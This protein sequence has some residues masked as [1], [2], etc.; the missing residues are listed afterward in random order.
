MMTLMFLGLGVLLV[1]REYQH[2]QLHL[3][4][5]ELKDEVQKQQQKHLDISQE[6]EKLNGQIMDEKAMD[7]LTGLPGIVMF[8]DRA[9]QILNFSKRYHCQFAIMILD[10][11][12]FSVINN[13]LGYEVGDKLLAA[14]AKRLK[15]EIRQIDTLATLGS[16]KFIF[17]LPQLEKGETA[18][19]VAQ[20]IQ[21]AVIRS[22]NIDGQALYIR[23]HMGIVISTTDGETIP[24]LLKN[25][26][27]ALD[28][29]KKQNQ[30]YQFYHQR[31]NELG[32][33]EVALKSFI[34]SKEIF[35]HLDIR[36]DWYI[37]MNN[38]EI[39]LMQASPILTHPQYGIIDYLELSRIAANANRQETIC[40]WLLNKAILKFQQNQLELQKSARLLIPVCIQQ[41]QHASFMPILT[42]ALQENYISPHQLVFEILEGSTRI[43][44]SSLEKMV[45]DLSHLGAG[46]SVSILGMGHFALQQITKIPVNYLKIDAS[47]IKNLM[48]NQES[49][50]ILN[51]MFAHAHEL[52]INIIAEGVNNESQQKLL[53]ALGCE[54]MQGPLIANNDFI[55]PEKTDAI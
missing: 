9:M 34:L 46:I 49:K 35:D 38:A 12:Q 41:I 37:N 54:I 3:H 53:L 22:F 36:S 55:P 26:S 40:A 29:A 30:S 45:N 51:M 15:E 8:E 14:L 5:T 11:E 17:L 13:K 44:I 39:H 43:D 50:F 20:R 4:L 6:L 24:E 10:I 18:A 52:N 16:G 1:V 42:K 25:A 7:K 48:N 31:I 21:D 27:H 2:R 19:Y 23:A 28:Q 33:R 47:L 32:K